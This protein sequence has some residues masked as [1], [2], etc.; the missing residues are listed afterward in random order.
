MAVAAIG[1]VAVASRV[2]VHATP[3]PPRVVFASTGLAAGRTQIASANIDGTGVTNLSN[4][5]STDS[6]PRVSPDGKLIAFDRAP[7][8]LQSQAVYVM[9]VDG[10]HQTALTDPAG[11]AAN[12]SWYP[13]GAHLVYDTGGQI[14]RSNADGSGRVQL[15]HGSALSTRPSISADGSQIVYVAT[16]LSPSSV[17]IHVASAIDMSHD[18]AL[19]D[20]SHFDANPVFGPPGTVLFDRGEDQPPARI[21]SVTTAT[22]APGARGTDLVVGA[23]P[24]YDSRANEIAYSAQVAGHF[25]LGIYDFTTRQAKV[26]SA[27]PADSFSFTVLAPPP[28]VAVAPSAA[29][30][31]PPTQVATTPSSGL[32]MLTIGIGILGVVLFG[33]G[34]VALWR[35]RTS[36]GVQRIETIVREIIAADPP[37]TYDKRP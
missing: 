33:G 23:Q 31:N 9:G 19:T 12:P 25:A 10:S 36:G 29:A 30:A 16:T 2:A 24:S 22:P 5:T 35:I 37:V 34:G 1:T 20:G 13:D 32:S 28:P 4:S 6:A 11:I 7:G 21:L 3:P 26:T 8:N 18:V 14:W 27:F 15:T 17:S